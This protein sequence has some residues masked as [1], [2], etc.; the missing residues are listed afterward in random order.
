MEGYGDEG[1]QQSW[2][3]GGGCSRQKEVGGGSVVMARESVTL[4]KRENID[5]NK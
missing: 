4:R 2:F 3:E 5:L 1:E